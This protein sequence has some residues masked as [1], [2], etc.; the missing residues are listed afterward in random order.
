MDEFYL[1][2]IAIILITAISASSFV[3]YT[4]LYDPNANE[5]GYCQVYAEQMLGQSWSG[6]YRTP[7]YVVNENIAKGTCNTPRMELVCQDTPANRQSPGCWVARS[8]PKFRIAFV[9][10][11]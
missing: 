2:F 5:P 11:I 9:E 8:E 1:L 10:E 7:P 3:L 4:F 6:Y